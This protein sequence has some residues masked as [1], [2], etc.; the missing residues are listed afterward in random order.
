MA[1]PSKVEDLEKKAEDLS[2]SIK[3]HSRSAGKIIRA[4][5]K[6]VLGALQKGVNELKNGLT[7]AE[8][9]LAITQNETVPSETSSDVVRHNS[10]AVNRVSIDQLSN[11]LKIT[12]ESLENVVDGFLKDLMSI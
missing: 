8:R 10:Q 2:A 4:G 7:M 12:F 9:S 3:S 11:A 5:Q 6:E 1:T